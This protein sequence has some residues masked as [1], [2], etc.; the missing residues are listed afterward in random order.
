MRKL[1]SLVMLLT[2]LLS[3]CYISKNLLLDP[4]AARQPWPSSTW[5]ETK[6]GVITTYHA[7]KRSDGWYDY[8]EERSDTGKKEEHKILLND[9]GTVN[10]RVLYAYAM[11]FE[12]GNEGAQFIYGIIATL[13]GGKW[14]PVTP[15]CSSEPAESIAKSRHADKDCM[16]TGRAQLLDALRA[17]ANTPQFA[18]AVDAP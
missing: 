7:T 2:I 14:K 13:P 17:Y 15:D 18:Q 12:P 1:Q 5:S 8:A 9:L 11:Q 16:F 6:N 4:S 3:A 10:G